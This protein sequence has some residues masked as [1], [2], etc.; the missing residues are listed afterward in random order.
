M[1]ED[2]HVQDTQA[3]QDVWDHDEIEK[4]AAFLVDRGWLRRGNTFQRPNAPA[5]YTISE[6]VKS[7]LGSGFRR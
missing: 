6:A 4:V 5:H 3:K 1:G 2:D 7:E